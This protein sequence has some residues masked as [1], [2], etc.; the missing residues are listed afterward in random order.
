MPSIDPRS[1]SL[2]PYMY[3]QVGR[4]TPSRPSDSDFGTV[5]AL[6]SQSCHETVP[7]ISL[8]LACT[9]ILSRGFSSASCLYRLSYSIIASAFSLSFKKVVSIF[10]TLRTINH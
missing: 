9:P 1:A 2:L 7:Q 3:S 4:L 5:M 6:V 8:D 10:S